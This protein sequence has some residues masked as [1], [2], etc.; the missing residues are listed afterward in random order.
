MNRRDLVITGSVSR[1][2]KDGV[3]MSDLLLSLSFM[4]ADAIVGLSLSRLETYTSRGRTIL[5]DSVLRAN[6]AT[7]LNKAILFKCQL[8]G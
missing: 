8:T 3:R 2:E 1:P 4:N 5:T 7:K 6:A